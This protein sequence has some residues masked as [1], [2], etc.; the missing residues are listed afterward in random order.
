MSDLACTQDK[1]KYPIVQA[2]DIKMAGEEYGLSA[3]KAVQERELEPTPMLLGDVDDVPG[4]GDEAP[5]PE[6]QPAAPPMPPPPFPFL[7]P[8]TLPQAPPTPLPD[9]DVAT[10]S[11][12]AAP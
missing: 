7:L 11:T 4:P 12:D 9:N 5:Q 10:S 8:A 6:P 2:Q 1:H 3:A